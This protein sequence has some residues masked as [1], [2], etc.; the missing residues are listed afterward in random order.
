MVINHEFVKHQDK[1]YFVYRKF[2]MSKIKED[3][4]FELMK[5]LECDIVLKKQTENVILY[6][7]K[8]IPELDIINN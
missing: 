6:Y 1:L 5:L 4:I 2:D 3:K 7:L 8:E